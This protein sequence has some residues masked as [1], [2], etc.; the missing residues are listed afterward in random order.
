LSNIWACCLVG[1][2]L[3]LKPQASSRLWPE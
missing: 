2:G 3:W 1:P